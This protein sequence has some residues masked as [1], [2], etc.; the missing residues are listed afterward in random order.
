[1][2]NFF[3]SLGDAFM[4]P[5]NMVTN[6]GKTAEYDAAE[7]PGPI[8]YTAIYEQQL[9]LSSEALQ[10][11]KAMADRQM[12]ISER[13]QAMADEQ[14]TYWKDTFQPIEKGIAASANVGLDPAYYADRA[15][16]DV[17]TAFDKAG[18][19]A[20]RNQMRLGIDPSSPKYQAQQQQLALARA[21][22]EAGARTNARDRIRDVNYARKLDAASL[23][24]NIPATAGTMLASGAN[25]MGQ[26]ANTSGQA[27]GQSLQTLSNV[28]NQQITAGG[29][30]L[31]A[32]QFNANLAFQKQQ[33]ANQQNSAMWQGIGSMAGNALPFLMM[34]G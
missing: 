27:Y 21:A 33:A 3:D 13:Q 6:M 9:A 22:S 16:A 31:D 20:G 11:Q 10:F 32:A 24:R 15:G 29:Q 1:M 7:I 30:A 19:I 5:I 26:A 23:G 25:T 34:A 12:K 28:A 2:A 4:A 17:G 14:Y 18:E 8:D